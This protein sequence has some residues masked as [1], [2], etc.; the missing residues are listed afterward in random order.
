MTKKSE[1]NLEVYEINAQDFIP[2]DTTEVEET[3]SVAGG[4]TNHDKEVTED[5]TSE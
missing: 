4:A 1:S 5:E 2:E 3:K